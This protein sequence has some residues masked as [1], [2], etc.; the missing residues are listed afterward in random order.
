[1]IPVVLGSF[2]I[3]RRFNGPPAS[4]QGGYAA[5]MLAGFCG[6]PAEVTLRLPPPL[7]R[8]LHVRAEGADRAILADGDAVLA[9]A[10]RVESVD[11]EPPVRPFFADAEAA[12]HRH[13]GR[14][15]DHELS[16]CFVCGP[17]REDGLRVSAG[18]LPAAPEVG[19]APFVPGEELC[20]D[21]VVRP[22]FVWAVLD[23]PSYTP[24]IWARERMS[25]LG[26]IAAE[27]LRDVRAGERLVVI[28]WDLEG[29]GRK[30]V[31]ASA[32]LTE[33]GE[34]VARA[35]STWIEPRA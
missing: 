6:E 9:E 21:S 1:M 23:C 20:E 16:N 18:P 33:E 5:G 12:T 32:L 31:T 26:R 19:A 24:R 29:E 3:D 27:R 13:P 10:R 15:R 11:V 14:G 28:G 17:E 8:E 4:A 25:L 22:E 7:G 2:T 35:R 34:V 30:H